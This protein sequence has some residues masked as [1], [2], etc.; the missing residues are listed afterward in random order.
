MPNTVSWLQPLQ[1]S[2][3]VLVLNYINY[4]AVTYTI[5]S[6]LLSHWM[7]QV[8]NQFSSTVMSPL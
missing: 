6:T 4:W 5:S 1:G 8:H 2:L 7:S 3:I